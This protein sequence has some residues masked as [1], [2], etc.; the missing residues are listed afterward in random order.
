MA[1]AAVADSWGQLTLALPSGATE[2]FDLRQPSVTIGREPGN[3]LVLA[4]GSVSRRH[5]RLDLQ[6]G[7]VAITDLGSMNGTFVNGSRIAGTVDLAS[8]C[9]IAVGSVRL[10]FQQSP[11]P[12][13]GGTPGVFPRA[14]RLNRKRALAVAGALLLLALVGSAI[15]FL[16]RRPTKIASPGTQSAAAPVAAKPAPPPPS[17]GPPSESL[18][19]LV[20]Y[21]TIL[22]DASGTMSEGDKMAKAKAAVVQY[23]NSVPDHIPLMVRVF[24]SGTEVVVPFSAGRAGF[25]A[26]GWNALDVGTVGIL[27]DIGAALDAT[28]GDLANSKQ[29]GLLVLISDGMGNV[30]SHDLDACRR[31]AQA[32]PHLRGDVIGIE[33]TPEGEWELEEIARILSGS[34]Q[35]TDRERLPQALQKETP[36]QGNMAQWKRP[37]R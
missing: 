20:K 18:W 9:E 17:A 6:A 34:F 37:Q 1:G 25:S 33:T 14:R 32:Y 15:A 10:G 11:A 4:D 21:V 26:P 27:T 24:A 12:V 3:D 16:A 2:A 7:R 19:D 29:N 35:R 36:A 22:I 23:A 28:S 30:P 13:A 5:A 31:L 8:P